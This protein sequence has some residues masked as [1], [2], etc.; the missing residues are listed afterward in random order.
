LKTEK[1]NI[2]QKE[3]I[4]F[5]EWKNQNIFVKYLL[6]FAAISQTIMF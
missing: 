2:R 5:A 3:T 4:K 6:I 1:K